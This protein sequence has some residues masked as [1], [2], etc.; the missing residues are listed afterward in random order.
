MAAD[1]TVVRPLDE[2]EARALAARLRDGRAS[3]RSPSACCTRTS[4]PRTSS[5]SARS[6]ARSCPGVPVSLSSEILR[7]QQEY[8]RTAT[9]VVN[10]YVRAADE[11]LRRR[12]PARARRGG[13][14]A[15]LTIMQSSGGVMTGGGRG[16]R[17]PSTR[18]S[19]ARRR[20]SSRRSRSPRRSATRT[21]SPSTWAARRPRPR[22]SRTAASRGARSTRSAPRSRSGSRLLRGSRRADPHP[23]DRHRRGRRGRR[24]DRLARRGGRPARRAAQRGRGARA[25]PAT[26]SAATE[27]TV[28]DANVV[29]RLHRARGRSASGA[30]DR[31]ARARRGGGRRAR[32]RLGLSTLEAARGIHDLANAAMMRALRAVSTEKGR[33]PRDFALVAYG[34]SGPVHAAALAAELGARTAVVPPLAGLFSAAGLLFARA[35]CHDVRFCRIERAR[36]RPRRC[37]GRL[38]AEMRDSSPRSTATPEWRR[39]ADVRYRGQSWSV[40]ID[41]PGELDAAALADARRALRGRA[42]A[43]LRH[44]ARARLAGRHPRAAAAS[45]SARARRRSRSARGPSAEARHAPRRL[46]RRPRRARGAGRLAR[47]A[48]CRARRRPAARRRV[49]HDGRRPARLDGRASTR[50]PGALVLDHVAAAATDRRPPHADAIAQRLV[51]NALETL[52]D[53]M[54]TTIFRT[55]HSAVVRD[56]MD[57]SA[58]LCAPDRRDGRAGGHDPAPARLDPERDADAA[59]ALRRRLRAGRRLRR[60]RPVRR[61]EPHARHL[62]RRS[63]PSPAT[64]CSASP[65]RSRT[66]ATSAAACPARC[67]CDKHRGLPGGPAPAVAPAVR[68]RRAGRGAVR[69]PPRERAHPTRAAR[70]PRRAGRGVPHRRPRAAGARR[71]ARAGRLVGLM[72]GL[73]DH[74]E[75][76]AARRDR[77]LAR[78]HRRPSPTTSDS[79]G[80]D[81]LRRAAHRRPDD[82]RRRADRR[83]LA[84]GA[85]GARRAQLHALVRRGGASTRRSW[86]PPRSTSR[87]PAARTRPI[88]VDDEARARSLTSSCRARRRCAASPA[89]ASPTSMNGALA[90]LIPDRVP[91]A[92]EGGSTLALFT[93]RRAT[94]SRSSTASSSSARGAA[95]R[96]RDGN[97]GLANP[98]ATHREHPRRGGRDRVAD[99]GRALRPRAG[100][101]RRRPLPRRARDRARRGAASRPDTTLHVRSDRQVHRPYGLAGGGAGA[102]LVER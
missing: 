33:D 98:C 101:G 16:R 49:R 45:R 70:R 4:T 84:L 74:T 13:V 15:P 18:S 87:A 75:A 62:R 61:R 7:E 80:I 88:T 95:G 8:E 82:P 34:G 39:I 48:R 54:A 66:T 31:L 27:P 43:P 41:L 81:V 89:T 26:A 78:R 51:G 47:V 1:G 25:R 42:R 36:A 19:P 96:S 32:R 35:E 67:A 40:P 97:D 20:A 72:D 30:L 69:D 64:R 12:P 76:A 99:R 28:T 10:A 102:A 91:A 55:A 56:A 86:P 57:F 38:D 17:G 44:A 5:G 79:D 90:Q 100:L 3:S 94:A 85:D 46:R 58:A 37:S 71:A 63:R 24:L 93:G 14:A 22:S 2:D 59:R 77:E 52:A 11:Q 65:S 92:G 60:Q 6:C 23:D 68:P 29:A 9:T 50:R 53:E 21:R 83:L 73:L